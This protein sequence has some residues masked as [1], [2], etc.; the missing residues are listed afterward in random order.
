MVEIELLSGRKHQIRRHAKLSGHAVVG[1][2]RYGSK[3]AA[4]YL[5]KNFAFDR[6]ALCACAHISTAGRNR[7]GNR[8]HTGNSG[9]DAESI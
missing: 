1:D 4:D 7:G 2:A 3:R 8:Y 9:P 6:L 5:K